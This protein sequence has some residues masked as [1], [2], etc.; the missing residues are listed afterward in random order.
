[1]A[2]TGKST[3]ARTIADNLARQKQLGASF[4]FSRGGG[5]LGNARKFFTTIAVQLA[6]KD[7]RLRYQISK[8]IADN[9]QLAQG[10]L[11][12][13]WKH[14]IFQPLI[15]W[16]EQLGQSSRLQ[17][18]NVVIDALDECEGDDA[19]KHLLRL[20]QINILRK[21]KV[22]IFITSR[23]ETAIRF[24]FRQMGEDTHRNFALHSIDQAITEQDI[25]VF[26]SHELDC[27]RKERGAQPGWPSDQ[28][29]QT[30]AH[31][32]QGLFIYAAT[33]LL[34][35]RNSKYSPPEKSL[36]RL[37]QNPTASSP[38]AQL[39]TIYTEVLEL[40]VL[41]DVDDLIREDLSMIFKEIVGAIVV[42]LD[43]LPAASLSKLV[44]KE[45]RI[46]LPVLGDL[47]SVLD[48][49]DCPDHPIQ[50]HHPSFRDFLLNPNRCSP[51]FQVDEKQTH[52]YLA[53][54]CLRLMSGYLKEDICDLKAPGTRTSTVSHVKIEHCIPR[55]LRYACLYWIDHVQKS[56]L[57]LCDGDQIHVFLQTHLLH[58]LEALSLMGKTSEAVLAI[59][60]LGLHISVR[61]IH[62]RPGY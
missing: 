1:M 47:H 32:A 2:G 11:E 19:V 29:I 7:H 50:L 57:H 61:A 26:L 12:H 15:K 8:A 9:P 43:V 3:I 44:D 62:V 40:S 5:D 24:G 59:T 34:Y 51:T 58:W 48:I 36:L 39:D 45:E 31:R 41:G 28:D 46:V 30:L 20:P 13:Q 18:L 16:E 4:F 52:E 17:R 25:R 54:S 22:R 53:K 49:P 55:E 6:S 42:L 23:P 33:C 35:I 10:G 37:I 60:S 21:V 27:I 56:N 38:E 14:L